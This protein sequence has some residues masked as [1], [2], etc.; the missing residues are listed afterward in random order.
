MS[1]SSLSA[2]SPLRPVLA[3]SRT[4]P[5]QHHSDRVDALIVSVAYNVPPGVI[6]GVN[7]GLT[8]GGGG[9]SKSREGGDDA[10]NKASS[11]LPSLS[12]LLLSPCFLF[13]SP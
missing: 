2:S 7:A 10:S 1:T 13:L 6:G 8:N 4:L 12:V 11:L 3:L 9:T 5:F